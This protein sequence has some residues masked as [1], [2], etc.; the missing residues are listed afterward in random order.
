[1]SEQV[2]GNVENLRKLIGCTI[3]GVK[4]EPDEKRLTLTLEDKAEQPLAIVVQPEVIMRQL[5]THS[6][7]Q[8]ALHIKE[9]PVTNLVREEPHP[10]D[11]S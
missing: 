7:F 3:I 2:E 1:M 9:I 6:N 8:V 10:L 4:L 11:K 5:G